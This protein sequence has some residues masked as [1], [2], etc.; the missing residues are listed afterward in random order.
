MSCGRIVDR[1]T[2]ALRLAVAVR[3]LN[4]ATRQ[5]KQRAPQ[6]RLRAVVTVRALAP[7]K[8]RNACARELAGQLGGWAPAPLQRDFKE[9]S[10]P[11]RQSE[12]NAQS[13]AAPGRLSFGL[14]PERRRHLIAAVATITVFGFALGLMFPLLALIMEARGLSPAVIG[15]NTA[16][17]PLGILLSG[18][19]V[20]PLVRWFGARRVVIGA[21]IISAL[22][23]LA[24]PFTPIFWAWFIVRFLQGL[25]V[26][27]LFAISEAW[28]V[29]AADGPYRSR[30]VALYSTVLAL[31]FGC[32]PAVIA[33][34]GIDGLL[35]FAVGAAV[36]TAATV[37]VLLLRDLPDHA[38]HATPAEGMPSFLGFFSKAPILLLAVCVFGI[39]DAA[40]LGFLPIY[41]L[42]R[43]L[44]QVDAA[45]I[46]SVLVFGN[47]FLQLPIG[48]L[49]DLFNKRLIMT[50]CVALTGIFILA[51]PA[52]MG[53]W[54]M[55][56]V[57][58]AAG[59]ASGGIYTV[60]LAEIGDRFSGLELVAGT[61]AMS[62][63]WGLGALI[64]A[65][66]TGWAMQGLGPDGF[67]W[68]QAVVM[69]L[70]ILAIGIR[71]RWKRTHVAG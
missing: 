17:N 41:G 29:E 67:P 33:V 35:P 52:A 14:T 10:E 24:Y 18:I 19:T 58:L 31:S 39:F 57:L 7:S 4:S 11:M 2:S 8:L 51:L 55:W 69:L 23:V 63:M 66:G 6:G 50:V 21:A 45:L 5:V 70:F 68:F 28:V 32:G 60:A 59:A 9:K 20:P 65:L 3:R 56:P 46:L 61:S 12:P 54:L 49:A 16:M 62:T 53:T 36:L 30:L 37:P 47:I 13:I 26:S 48:W 40:V 25:A 42:A 71:E 38:S 64:G 43:G 27:T 44:G 34:T 15:Y 1:Q 22:L